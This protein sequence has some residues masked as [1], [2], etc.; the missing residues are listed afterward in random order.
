MARFRPRSIV[1]LVL[2]AFA[3]ALA[4]FVAAVVTAVVQVDAFATASRGAV[5]NAAA[6]ANESRVLA[7]NAV[8]MRRQLGQYAALGND[9]AYQR[10]LDRR[11]DFRRAL[12]NLL[13]QDLSGLDVDRL[14]ALGNEEAALFIRIE[15]AKRGI[16]E[17][18]WRA[19]DE[20][21]AALM[22]QARVVLAESDLLIQERANAVTG[23]AQSMQQTL[24]VIAVAAVP[25]TVLLV[26]LFTVLITRPLSAI[27]REIRRLGGQSLE[28]PVV[29]T[30][31]RDVEALADDLEW[32]RRRLKALEQ[33]K[34]S[35]LQQ[36]SHE[37]KTPLT[38]I[39]E[40]SE[41]LFESLDDRP[42][43]AEV[44]G[45]LRENG[46]RLQKLI[47]DLLAFAKT[48]DLA[49]ELEF[50][51]AV[52]LADLIDGA[53]D[54]L[55]MLAETKA[56]SIDTLLE[57]LEV[58]CDA[59]KIRTVVD[60]LLTN[61]IK[62]TP[63]GGRIRVVLTADD[64]NAVID[65]IDSGPGVDEAD[66]DRIFEPFGQGSAVYESSVKGTGLGLSIAREYV[67]A[68]GGS[69]ELMPGD[70]GAHFRVVLPAA[71]P[72]PVSGHA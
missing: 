10:F 50:R 28:T 32:L 21:L 54:G 69:I 7:D 58:R 18:D 34:A 15:D 13:D 19:E 51:A 66:R 20:A 48:Q 8:E 47:E 16:V 12:A 56:I 46:L 2:V 9:D 65:V 30:G 23:R 24:L 25:A 17:A 64:E 3:F 37:L 5:L 70:D 35:F 36:I 63:Q 52:D 59:G 6:A 40:G 45:L 31:P 27:G 41:L 61:A 72:A 22:S 14:V 68:H 43:D 29:V 1:S 49:M 42:E 62:Y 71:G 57:P 53:A 55:A 60:N 44:A 11:A 67:E 33:Q 39:R 4:P 38:T 26:A